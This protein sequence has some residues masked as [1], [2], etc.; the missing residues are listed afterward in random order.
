[1]LT[2]LHF[3]G[4]E[5]GDG[6]PSDHPRQSGPTKLETATVPSCTDTKVWKCRGKDVSLCSRCSIA[7]MLDRTSTM[8]LLVGPA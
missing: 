1:M 6:H 4:A 7:H 3:K 5:A 2:A 8:C